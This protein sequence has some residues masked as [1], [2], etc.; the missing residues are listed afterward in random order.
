MASA[1]VVAFGFVVF[2]RGSSEFFLKTV[3]AHRMRRSV[4]HVKIADLFGGSRNTRWC[5]RVSDGRVPIRG[6]R[7]A[8]QPSWGFRLRDRAKAPACSS[9][10]RGGCTNT[11]A[12][13]ILQDK[14]CKGSA[15]PTFFEPSFFVRCVG[16]GGKKQKNRPRQSLLGQDDLL[17][18]HPAWRKNYA[19]LMHTDIC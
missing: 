10:R 1:G 8:A 18:C 19:R 16:E 7:R 6:P 12:F 13:P 9:Y 11:W 17:R 2:F 5:H 14:S 4:H 3:R 15:F